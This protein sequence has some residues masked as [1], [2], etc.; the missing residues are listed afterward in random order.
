MKK[1]ILSLLAILVLSCQKEDKPI[2]PT[3]P[4]GPIMNNFKFEYKKTNDIPP[5]NP[6]DWQLTAGYMYWDGQDSVFGVS[7]HYDGSGGSFDF[8]VSDTS[9]TEVFIMISNTMD[10]F[11][12]KVWRNDTLIIEYSETDSQVQNWIVNE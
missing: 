8:Q 4:T 3:V 9:F 10:P 11:T 6:L 12:A 5:I 7:R 2:E 1:I